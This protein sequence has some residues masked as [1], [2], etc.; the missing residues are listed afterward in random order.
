[1]VDVKVVK[2]FGHLSFQLPP[3]LVSVSP[4][5]PEDAET[6]VLTSV[7]QQYVSPT[8]RA[9]GAEIVA[10]SVVVSVGSASVR[11]ELPTVPQ[12]TPLHPSQHMHFPLSRLQTPCPLGPLH[13]CGQVSSSSN[14]M[15]VSALKFDPQHCR[16]AWKICSSFS[17][18]TP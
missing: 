16:S 5:V 4:A 8:Y 14:R 2:G 6:N 18:V 13:W 15:L 17:R 12:S 3:G 10:E 11:A 9:M 1:V 7:F